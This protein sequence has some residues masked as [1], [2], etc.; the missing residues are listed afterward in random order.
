[1]LIHNVIR[2]LRNGDFVC[3]HVFCWAITIYGF[4]LSKRK[5]R[6][7]S[8]RKTT[9]LMSLKKTLTNILITNTSG[10]IFF[11]LSFKS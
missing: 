1:V 6:V 2:Y 11:F 4:C 5:K 7:R 8:L 10:S 9:E 3:L